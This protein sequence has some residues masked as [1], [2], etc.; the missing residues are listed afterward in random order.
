MA[1]AR[2]FG[3]NTN[4]GSSLVYDPSKGGLEIVQTLSNNLFSDKTG[5]DLV[6]ATGVT[7]KDITPPRRPPRK[8]RFVGGFNKIFGVFRVRLTSRQRLICGGYVCGS[9]GICVESPIIDTSLED[10]KL[11]CGDNP[12]EATDNQMKKV[13]YFFGPAG[14]PGTRGLPYPWDINA[15]CATKDGLNSDP[16]QF[17]EVILTGPGGQPVFENLVAF[18]YFTD[19]Y[20]SVYTGVHPR[21]PFGYQ[22]DASLEDQ[23]YYLSTD[24]ASIQSK[25]NIL[26][27][28][29]LVLPFGTIPSLDGLSGVDHF[30]RFTNA[31]GVSTEDFQAP[32]PRTDWQVRRLLNRLLDPSGTELIPQS[33]WG[34]ASIVI[35]KSTAV[36]PPTAITDLFDYAPIQVFDSE[37]DCPPGANFWDNPPPPDDGIDFGWKYYFFSNSIP[38]PVAFTNGEIGLQEGFNHFV[39]TTL[40]TSSIGQ[41]ISRGGTDTIAMEDLRCAI[42]SNVNETDTDNP[43][44]SSGEVPRKERP[45]PFL[46]PNPEANWLGFLLEDYRDRNLIFEEID[47]ADDGICYKELTQIGVSPQDPPIDPSESESGQQEWQNVYFITEGN[48]DSNETTPKTVREHIIDGTSMNGIQ[49]AYADIRKAAPDSL[50]CPADTDFDA[51]ANFRSVPGVQEV[52]TNFG[53]TDPDEEFDPVNAPGNTA[54]EI[55]S[56]GVVVQQASLTEVTP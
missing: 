29:D 54:F 43:V 48:V 40:G 16:W 51:V 46:I 39:V 17:N 42:W 26:Y 50:S 55:V 12:D 28:A 37:V 21:I 33:N 19:F 6:G 7:S 45:T 13:A 44:L 15:A 56:L 1:R 36:T 24:I 20:K 10:C 49:F 52:L 11:T 41:V 27:P 4:K 34:Y 23:W 47:P 30:T 25:G 2:F 35:P 14:L 31:G 18:P 3:T 5:V 53:I 8:R 22:F 32:A 38:S 9:E